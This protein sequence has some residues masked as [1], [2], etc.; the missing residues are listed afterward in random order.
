MA[1]TDLFGR[2]ELEK[3]LIKIG[4]ASGDAFLGG[5]SG[6]PDEETL[7]GKTL[8]KLESKAFNAFSYSTFK[9]AIRCLSGR[10]E[11][12]EKV[13]SLKGYYFGESLFFFFFSACLALIDCSPLAFGKEEEEEEDSIVL[14]HAD[15]Q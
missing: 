6:M 10:D 1:V 9:N 7:R 13:G 12:G 14:A 11:E 8:P 15:T 2:S 3:S 5:G 4:M